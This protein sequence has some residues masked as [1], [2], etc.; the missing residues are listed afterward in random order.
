[1]YT[2]FKNNAGSQVQMVPPPDHLASASSPKGI[3]YKH[4]D[5]GKP[6]NYK[7]NKKEIET[8]ATPKQ[9]IHDNLDIEP[10]IKDLLLQEIGKMILKTLKIF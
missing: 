3:V 5:W 7:L 1:M 9:Q 10:E 2:S 8:H 4:E 6:I